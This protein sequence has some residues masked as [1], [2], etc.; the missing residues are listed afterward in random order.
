MT[1]GQLSLR[2]VLKFARHDFLNELQI[3]LMHIDL[4]NTTEAKKAIMKTTNGMGQLSKLGKLGLPETETWLL[5]FDWIF[6]D[7]RK[8]LLCS[9]KSGTREADD[10]ELVSC[11]TRIFNG[12]KEKLDLLSEYEV[13]F[14]ITGT[15]HEWA[16][17]IIIEGILPDNIDM[18]IEA[19][20]FSV[21]QSILLNLW[22][23]T[24]RGR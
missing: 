13:Q 10:L 16:I 24:I 1:K 11:L 15:E 17:K 22:T 6:T 12:T 9:I 20:T 18:P 19:E 14:E 4:E 23:F 3:V 5:T 7:F 21:E 2:E 8:T